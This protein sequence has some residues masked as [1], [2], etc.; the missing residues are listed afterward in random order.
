[1]ALAHVQVRGDDRSHNCQDRHKLNQIA[2]TE[3]LRILTAPLNPI[4]LASQN[5]IVE[6]AFMF[7]DERT[8]QKP[9]SMTDYLCD[10][11]PV[12]SSSLNY[13]FF[14]RNV[15]FYR[16]CKVVRRIIDGIINHFA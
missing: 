3:I 1:M 8:E 13:S 2:P 12:T 14:I 6:E 11:W 5:D 4:L 7:E 10:L 9:I 15:I 16:H